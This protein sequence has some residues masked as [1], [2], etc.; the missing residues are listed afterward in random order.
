MKFR[1]AW[2]LWCGTVW[3]QPLTFDVCAVKPSAPGG[4]FGIIRVMPGN[5]AYMG[6]NM[7]LRVMMSV[8]YEVTD[9]QI[10]GGPDW[11]GT[12]R[13]DLDC[14]SEHSYSTHELHQMLARALEDRFQMK[15]RRNKREMPVWA[16]VVDRGASKLT[17]HPE[18]DLDHPPMGPGPNGRGISGRNISME[19]LA[20]NL[21]RQLDRNVVDRTGLS[22]SYDLVLE[23]TRDAPP[24]PDGVA[25]Q[26]EP[27]PTVFQALREQAGL[28]LDPAR[29]PVEYLIIDSAIRPV[30]N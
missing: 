4:Q 27:G 8:A 28:R 9:R 11:T 5:Q 26:P 16:L 30:A 25:P 20:L 2:L 17:R 29:A 6:R 24:G 10:A 21:S 7:T 1:A 3:G 19:F 18:G 14:K 23:Y 13:F 15:L 12:E 22:G